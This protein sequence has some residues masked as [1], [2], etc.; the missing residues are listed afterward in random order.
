MF[1]AHF[2][3]AHLLKYQFENAHFEN[4]HFENA[5]SEHGH[6]SKFLSVYSHF[7]NADFENAHELFQ[8]SLNLGPSGQSHKIVKNLEFSPSGQRGPKLPLFSNSVLF[9]KLLFC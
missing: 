2:E 4:A 1:N 8:R 6:S 5:H 7:E 9:S 3:N